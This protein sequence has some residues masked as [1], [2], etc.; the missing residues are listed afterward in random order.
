MAVISVL[1]MSQSYE[2]KL[3]WLYDFADLEYDGILIE[4]RQFSFGYFS[5]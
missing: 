2:L 3:E 1:I 5:R 4:K